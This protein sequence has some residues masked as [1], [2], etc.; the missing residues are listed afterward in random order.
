MSKASKVIATFKV[1]GFHN[2]PDAPDGE[3]YLRAS[4]RHLFTFRIEVDVS[5]A[6]RDVEFH[7]L[8]AHAKA[9]IV[10]RL[11]DATNDVHG[12]D[13]GAQSCEHLAQGLHDRLSSQFPSISAIEV[14]ED[15]ECGARLEF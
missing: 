6:D 12:Y 3:R 7:V 13:F 11:Y 4:H 14:W 2:W 1:P 10:S 15:D 9:R 8:L 5:H